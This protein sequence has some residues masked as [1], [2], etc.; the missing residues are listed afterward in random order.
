MFS[1]VNR[2]SWLNVLFCVFSTLTETSSL[3]FCHDPEKLCMCEFIIV[4]IHRYVPV[5]LFIKQS[6]IW[7]NCHNLHLVQQVENVFGNSPTSSTVHCA[8]SFS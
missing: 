8:L 7:I 3:L 6:M 2:L 1:Q 4:I 5:L